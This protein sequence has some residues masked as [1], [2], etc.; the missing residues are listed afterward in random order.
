M[1]VSIKQLLESGVHFGHQTKRWNPKMARYIFGER[2]GIY[3]VNLEK[4]E[5]ELQKACEFVN[6]CAA[7]G[8]YILFVGTK[9]QAQQAIIEEANRCGM[10][11]VDQRWLGGTLTNFE[12]I[13]RSI[14]RLEELEKMK[15]TG[16]FDKLKKKEVAVLTKEMLKLLKNLSGI[17]NMDRL[18][19]VLFVVDAKK[20]ETAVKEA[21]R[22]KIPVIALVDTNSDPDVI[23]YVI[24]GNDDAIKSIR[25]ICGAIADSINEGKSQLENIRKSKEVIKEQEKVSKSQGIATLDEEAVEDEKAVK[26]VKKQLVGEIKKKPIK[27]KRKVE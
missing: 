10:F 2:N 3:I 27:V 15:E 7:R 16:V 5:K 13:R 25:L 4:T 1:L 6:K 21:R 8:E 9:K 26:K 22:L 20:E 14:K 24:P 12:T 17:R 18:P 19:G 23:D 11:Y